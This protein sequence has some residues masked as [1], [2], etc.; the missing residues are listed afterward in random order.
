VKETLFLGNRAEYEPPLVDD[1]MNDNDKSSP[2]ALSPADRSYVA[3]TA[4]VTFV[5]VL[6]LIAL[7][8]LLVRR[9]KKSRRT[10]QR[11]LQL[12]KDST[13]AAAPG[14]CGGSRPSEDGG[15]GGS[16]DSVDGSRAMMRADG[17]INSNGTSEFVTAV[18]LGTGS[19]RTLLASNV[20]KHQPPSAATK[21]DPDQHSVPI[22]PTSTDSLSTSTPETTESDSAVAAP[23]IDAEENAAIY[24][25]AALVESKFVIDVLPPL[26]PTKKSFKNPPPCL[27]SLKQRRRRRRKKKKTKQKLIRV[28]SRENVKEMET[29]A[30]A[31]ESDDDNNG[32][33]EEECGSEYSWST[34]GEDSEGRSSR[35]PS[36]A[37]SDS[38]AGTAGRG[39]DG[40]NGDDED[41]PNLSPPSATRSR[42]F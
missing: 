9:Q 2:K 40:S 28:N 14:T 20:Q 27:Q 38:G 34:D 26:P 31:E 22:L 42:S 11:A 16:D 6:V 30:E 33:E 12:D 19:S 8:L 4:I 41:D 21:K 25:A 17:E 18:S 24:A 13:D 23:P 7:G 5:A 15:D 35:D 3:I 1:I 29:I 10:E 32:L 39:G 37:R 36:P